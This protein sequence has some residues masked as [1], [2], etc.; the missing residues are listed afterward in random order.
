MGVLSE[1]LV[2][3]TVILQPPVVASNLCTELI[4]GE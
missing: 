3:T 4:G 1:G 2:T